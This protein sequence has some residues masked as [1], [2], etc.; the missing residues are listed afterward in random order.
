MSGTIPCIK[1]ERGFRSGACLYFCAIPLAWELL[2]CVPNSVLRSLDHSTLLNSST[3]SRK[4]SQKE[5]QV[6]LYPIKFPTVKQILCLILW[7]STNLL[8]QSFLRCSAQHWSP[9]PYFQPQ[10]PQM[11]LGN[12]KPLKKGQ[13]RFPDRMALSLLVGLGIEQHMFILLACHS[14]RWRVGTPGKEWKAQ[15]SAVLSL[16]TAADAAP[17]ACS[18]SF[19]SLHSS[20]APSKHCML[21]QHLHSPPPRNNSRAWGEMVTLCLRYGTAHLEVFLPP[22]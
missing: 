12:L 20:P 21:E 6:L 9:L 19:Y 17:C 18:P 15:C 10:T 5:E 1:A 22:C 4:G 7:A 11:G 13:V 2:S 14:S 8:F 16:V 3:N